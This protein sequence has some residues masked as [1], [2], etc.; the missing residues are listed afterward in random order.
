LQYQLATELLPGHEGGVS[1]PC[2]D[3]IVTV[4]HTHPRALWV[5]RARHSPAPAS[6]LSLLAIKNESRGR[7]RCT[8]SMVRLRGSSEGVCGGMVTGHWSVM[9][10]NGRQCLSPASPLPSPGASPGHP[11]RRWCSHRCGRHHGEGV[12]GGPGKWRLCGSA[13]RERAVGRGFFTGS[14]P[15]SLMPPIPSWSAFYN[16]HPTTRCRARLLPMF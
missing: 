9:P 4:A 8:R 13:G 12:A 2:F 7:D 15:S 6:A 3:S 16:H 11:V 5:G 14:C 1:C 10:P